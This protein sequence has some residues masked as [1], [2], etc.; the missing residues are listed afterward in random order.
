LKQFLAREIFKTFP[1]N[2][3]KLEFNQ[4]SDDFVVRKLTKES[5]Y[6]LQ[7]S[8]KVEISESQIENEINGLVEYEMGF[9]KIIE[10]LIQA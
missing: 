5:V 4:S 6:P 10:E 9:S 3:F 2:S 7:I 8:Y 1:F